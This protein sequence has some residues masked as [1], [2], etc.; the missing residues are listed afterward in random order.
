MRCRG[1]AQIHFIFLPIK[2]LKGKTLEAEGQM[3]GG[4]KLF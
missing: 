2:E 4:F 1:L 3:A